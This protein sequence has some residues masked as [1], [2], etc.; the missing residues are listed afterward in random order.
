[1][2][3]F[4]SLVIRIPEWG[5]AT[6]IEGVW[7]SIGVVGLVATILGVRRVKNDQL[8]FQL[9]RRH[10]ELKYRKA[11]RLVWRSHLRREALRFV[12]MGFITAIGVWGM[13]QPSLVHPAVITVTGLLITGFLVVVV[14]INVVQSVL[15]GRVR[16]ELTD[17]LN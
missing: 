12:Q 4:A 2:G 8:A 3:L 6:L 11:A 10:E 7:T 14:A 9:P 13:T 5:N 1:M 16:S 15:D 17:L